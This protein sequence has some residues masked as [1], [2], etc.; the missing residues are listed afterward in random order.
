MASMS[1]IDAILAGRSKGRLGTYEPL[2][3][4]VIDPSKGGKGGEV[5][6]MLR[7]IMEKRMQG[8]KMPMPAGV[9]GDT[10]RLGGNPSETKARE[11]AAEDFMKK[12]EGGGDKDWRQM[13][14]EFTG[15]RR[16]RY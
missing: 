2:Q 7:K 12:R 8:G 15:G 9:M 13:M 10:M 4:P 6:E 16:Y 11:G 1:I 14:E 5:L 3:G